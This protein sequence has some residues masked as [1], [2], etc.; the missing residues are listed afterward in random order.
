MLTTLLLDETTLHRTWT[1]LRALVTVVRALV[2]A[3]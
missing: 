3:L 2:G 1:L